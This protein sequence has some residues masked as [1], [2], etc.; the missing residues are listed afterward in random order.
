MA[1]KFFFKT[2]REVDIVKHPNSHTKRIAKQK[3]KTNKKCLEVHNNTILKWLLL[4]NARLLNKPAVI[5][6]ILVYESKNVSLVSSDPY[7]RI[8]RKVIFK[9]VD[10]VMQLAY[11]HF[12]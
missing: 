1:S 3:A 5:K 6:T 4:V 12:L 11:W 2:V 10:I 9:L 7:V 8:K